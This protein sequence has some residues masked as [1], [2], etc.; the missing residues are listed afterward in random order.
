MCISAKPAHF[1][2]TKIL[3]MPV[4]ERH[5]TAYQNEVENVSNEPNAMIL[6][7]PGLTKQEYFV[8]TSGYNKFMTEIVEQ[9]APRSRGMSLGMKSKGFEKFTLGMYTIGLCSSLT[10]ITQFLM[11]EPLEK[12]PGLRKEL[13]EFFVNHYANWSFAVCLFDKGA[14][15]KSQPIAYFY[16]PFVKDLLFFPTMDSHDGYAP[17]NEQVDMDHSFILANNVERNKTD[18]F[19]Q[20]VPEF[21]KNTGYEVINSDDYNFGTGDNG[22]CYVFNGKFSK[23]F[24]IAID[25]YV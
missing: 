17:K 24:D 11:S 20:P 8:D 14:K 7:I 5:F 2:K 3:T 6:P 13:I 16:E 22:D 23:A 21:L 18:Y 1:S 10:G 15:M 25:S 19:T 12:V 4:G 9:D